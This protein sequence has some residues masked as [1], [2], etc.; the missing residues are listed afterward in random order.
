[1]ALHTTTKCVITYIFKGVFDNLDRSK[2]TNSLWPT[3]FTAEGVFLERV[4][5][6]ITQRYTPF[7]LLVF[8]F[9]LVPCVTSYL[10]QV[11]EYGWLG[12]EGR[13]HAANIWLKITIK[14]I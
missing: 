1:M 9:L 10:I 11:G 2:S 8:L 7:V 6:E 5:Q 3:R 13:Y 14:S 4:G 12:G